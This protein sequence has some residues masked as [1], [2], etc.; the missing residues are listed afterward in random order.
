MKRKQSSLHKSKQRQVFVTEI[1]RNRGQQKNSCEP[2]TRFTAIKESQR[3]PK[4]I[5]ADPELESRNDIDPELDK[6]IRLWCPEANLNPTRPIPG[7][8]SL[9]EVKN[10]QRRSKSF[11][12]KIK[13][14]RAR[15]KRQ[16]SI[17]PNASNIERFLDRPFIEILGGVGCALWFARALDLEPLRDPAYV[18]KFY[19]KYPKHT[20]AK[21]TWQHSLVQARGSEMKLLLSSK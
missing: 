6:I 2:S 21:K 13:K 18:A 4:M 5:G 15:A 20:S 14:M 11:W 3:F 1:L 12:P 9:A 7:E 8:I 10:I 16:L 19:P 17:I